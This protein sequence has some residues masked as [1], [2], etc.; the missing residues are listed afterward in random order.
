MVKKNG[1]HYY[2]AYVLHS[3][4][5]IVCNSFLVIGLHRCLVLILDY[6]EAFECP[7][8]FATD[9]LMDLRREKEMEKK[10]SVGNMCEISCAGQHGKKAHFSRV[11]QFH[12]VQRMTCFFFVIRLHRLSRGVCAFPIF[13]LEVRSKTV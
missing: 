8:T 6:F 3:K 1:A 13:P 7:V 12:C 2:L 10:L 4:R 9:I 11:S 5:P